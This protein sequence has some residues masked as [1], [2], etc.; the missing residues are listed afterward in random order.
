ML[1]QPVGAVLRANHEGHSLGQRVSSRPRRPQGTSREGGRDRLHGS[2]CNQKACA[3]FKVSYQAVSFQVT[4]FTSLFAVTTNLGRLVG[5]ICCEMAFFFT[6]PA[7]SP[8]HL[9]ISALGL[10]MTVVLSS[11]R[12]QGEGRGDT[13]LHHN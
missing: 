13:L 4:S 5:A 1:V 10:G 8:W 3:L 11:L 7:R 9:G 6:E 2:P 12:D